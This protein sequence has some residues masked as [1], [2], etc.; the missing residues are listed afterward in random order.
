MSKS[1]MFCHTSD[2]HIP[3]LLYGGIRDFLVHD[4]DRG[5]RYI[6]SAIIS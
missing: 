1:I 5:V 4:G 2:E 3:L 6:S